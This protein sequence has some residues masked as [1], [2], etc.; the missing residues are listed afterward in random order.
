MADSPRSEIR[1]ETSDKA[2]TQVSCLLVFVRYLASPVRVR[3][4]SSFR[5]IVQALSGSV[6][7]VGP[8]FMSFDS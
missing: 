8:F 3:V 6:L 2:M 5:V 7:S 4:I 1:I